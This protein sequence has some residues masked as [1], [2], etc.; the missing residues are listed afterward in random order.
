MNRSNQNFNI[1]K[2]LFEIPEDCLIE[3]FLFL[4]PWEPYYQ[5]LRLVCSEWKKNIDKSWTRV[6]WMIK[7]KNQTFE[8]FEKHISMCKNLKRLT[9]K[10][11]SSN[12]I[13][14]LYLENLRNSITRLDFV[15]L[16]LSE[17]SINNFKKLKIL[18]YY[19]CD[20]VECNMLDQLERVEFLTEDVY[21]SDKIRKNM[22]KKMHLYGLEYNYENENSEI[23]DEL[24][25]KRIEA[26]MKL[27]EVRLNF[28]NDKL[29]VFGESTLIKKMLTRNDIIGLR[30]CFERKYPFDND[31]LFEVQ[32]PEMARFL[33]NEVGLNPGLYGK[34]FLKDDLTPFLYTCSNILSQISSEEIASIFIESAKSEEE[35]NKILYSTDESKNTAAHL[36]LMK[37]IFTRFNTNLIKMLFDK[38][39]FKVNLKNNNGE[40][41]LHVL[42][43]KVDFD[44]NAI[45]RIFLVEYL[46]KKGVDARATD[47]EGNLPLHLACQL[48][49]S[50]SVTKVLINYGGKN[51]INQ[52]NN[53]GKTPFQVL[54]QNEF[55]YPLQ[56]ELFVLNCPEVLEKDE[57]GDN[58]LHIIFS[59]RGEFSEKILKQFP[60]LLKEQNNEGQTPFHVAALEGHMTLK[61]I[62]H[63]D[64]SVANLKDNNGRTILN[65]I[66]CSKKHYTDD[67]IHKLVQKG[68]D[69][70]IPDNDLNTPL[71][72]TL[73]KKVFYKCFIMVRALLNYY[74]YET[75]TH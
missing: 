14:I 55:F 73:K 26:L 42:L 46:C 71:H 58:I 18:G 72:N 38:Y 15:G 66:A 29:E 63:I 3:I 30:F 47:N 49:Y 19:L 41:Y 56:I 68:C 65:C 5:N 17:H 35:R 10:S 75:L 61:L 16:D 43:K 28:L 20:I 70:I 60:H 23:S 40:G 2:T 57:K 32:T 22:K 31:F 54:L 21:S 27:E 44:D 62:K 45:D 6:P 25:K 8:G 34:D 13:F 33:V 7:T 37:C 4:E 36:A 59:K 74:S 64:N 51:T 24:K 9:W 11:S 12:L 48:D 39:K 69:P 50:Y 53:S 52:K 1:S 67:I